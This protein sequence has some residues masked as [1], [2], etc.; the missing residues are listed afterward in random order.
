LFRAGAAVTEP[1]NGSDKRRNVKGSLKYCKETAQ[2]IW[3]EE[4]RRLLESTTT[5]GFASGCSCN[6]IEYGQSCRL[7]GRKLRGG[8]GNGFLTINRPA[9]I[10]G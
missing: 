10:V 6:Q 7:H 1:V 5:T 8:L 3:D 2:Q 4:T 9:F